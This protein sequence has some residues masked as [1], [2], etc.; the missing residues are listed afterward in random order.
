MRYKSKPK[1]QKRLSFVEACHEP[2]YFCKCPIHVGSMFLVDLGKDNYRVVC[3][4]GRSDL[5][6]KYPE[7]FSRDNFMEIPCVKPINV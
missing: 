1:A 6:D 7:D 5:C 3:R 4:I 2:E